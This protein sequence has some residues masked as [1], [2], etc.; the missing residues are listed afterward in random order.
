MDS[1]S[2]KSIRKKIRNLGSY[3]SVLFLTI[4]IIST[5]TQVLLRYVFSYSI[6]GLSEFNVYSLLW[7]VFLAVPYTSRS[8]KH[9]KAEFIY[10]IIDLI[11]A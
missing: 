7:I 8:E 10:R 2:N 6:S 11:F 9:I 4:L 1:N 3:I 5:F